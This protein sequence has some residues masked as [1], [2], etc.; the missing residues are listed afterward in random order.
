ML[1]RAGGFACPNFARHVAFCK[2]QNV[3]RDPICSCRGYMP[4]ASLV[5]VPKLELL[6]VE[7]GTPLIMT[8][9]GLKASPRSSTFIRSRHEKTFE[10][11]KSVLTTGSER[12]TL[13]PKLPKANCGM[14]NAALLTASCAVGCCRY[15][16]P[17]RS[18]CM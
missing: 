10:R 7:F 13:R 5:I 4:A 15:G 9:N 11:E 17:I 1:W 6:T 2:G 3:I 18:G 14:P 8:L 16:L 12:K